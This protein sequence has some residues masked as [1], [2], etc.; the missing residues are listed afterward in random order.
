MS[1]FDRCFE[2]TVG[3]EGGYSD[4]PNDRGNWTSG[5]VGIGELRGTKYGISAMS[6]PNLDIQNLTLDQA[7]A[8]Y[9]TDYWAKVN[10]SA[11]PP[12]VACLVFDAGVNS[13]TK[14]AGELLQVALGFVGNAVDGDIGGMTLDAVHKATTSDLQGLLAEYSARRIVYD[15]ETAQWANDALGWSRRVIGLPFKALVLQA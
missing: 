10:G 1:V 14:K 12:A 2:I 11:L 5:Q 7:K 4:D 15:T 9:A 13:G 8:I 6:Y 3:N